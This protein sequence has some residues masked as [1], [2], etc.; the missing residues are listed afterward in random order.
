[1][2]C[3][4]CIQ[5]AILKNKEMDDLLIKAKKQAI[6]DKE[7]KAICYDEIQGYFITG[8]FTAIDQ[9]FQIKQFVHWV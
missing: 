3:G 4:G 9:R 1:M 6:E 8:S 7:S 2:S 5:E